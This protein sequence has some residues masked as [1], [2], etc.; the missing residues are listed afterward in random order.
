MAGPWPRR[1][2]GRRLPLLPRFHADGPRH[3]DLRGPCK[4]RNRLGRD[5]KRNACVSPSSDPPPKKGEGDRSRLCLK[6]AAP[7]IVEN[8]TILWLSTTHERQPSHI[9]RPSN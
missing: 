1:Q 5:G 6:S 2:A 3:E 4:P 9:D 8:F 7:H